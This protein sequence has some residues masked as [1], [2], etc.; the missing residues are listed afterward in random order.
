[1]S[2]DKNSN[3]EYNVGMLFFGGI[4]MGDEYK[5]S[6]DLLGFVMEIA[7]NRHQEGF[8][9]MTLEEVYGRLPR[10]ISENL[11]DILS[12]CIGNPELN[13]LAKS[14]AKNFCLLVD[15]PTNEKKKVFV[16][17]L[18]NIYNADIA[19]RELSPNKRGFF[20]R[21]IDNRYNNYIERIKD[22]IN[23]GSLNKLCRDLNERL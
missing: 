2:I 20:S 23:D 11:I 18:K 21:I 9:I 5:L 7:D 15:N 8:I 3:I 6:D 16:K 10:D 13:A 1:M 19:K 17:V 12:Y 4:E 14:R 22:Y